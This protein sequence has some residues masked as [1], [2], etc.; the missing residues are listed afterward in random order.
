MEGL[1]SRRACRAGG[2]EEYGLRSNLTW[3]DPQDMT[4]EARGPVTGYSLPGE[5]LVPGKMALPAQSGPGG[6]L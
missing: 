5:E 4:L 1:P 3:S 6:Q 2:K